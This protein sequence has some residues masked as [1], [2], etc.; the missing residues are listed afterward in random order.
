MASHF[1]TPQGR[2]IH[3]VTGPVPPHELL[4]EANWALDMYREASL[5]PRTS[6]ASFVS[7]AHQQAA[8][9]TMRPRDRKVHEFLATY[10]LAP[11]PY[12]YQPIFEK[13]LGER[14]STSAPRLAQASL[15]LDFARKTSRPLLFVLHDGQNFASPNFDLTLQR[16]INE[17]VVIVMPIR[18]APAL[19]QLTNQPP[20][21]ASGSA[22]PLFVVA[23]WDCRQ[24]AS[25]SGLN[26]QLLMRTLA[27]GWADALEQNPRSVG[28]LVR[29][30]QLLRKADPDAAER[31]KTLTIRLREEAKSARESKRDDSAK[32]VA[33]SAS[34]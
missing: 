6:Q 7:L 25:V 29:A 30:Q 27:S 1:L 18:E 31:V 15:R 8:M 12:A 19:S 20:Y 23:H 28:N 3:S 10:P 26:T 17:Y 14:V 13:I 34:L 32:L 4:E 24:I 11:L 16:L 33:R 2:L 21:V 5:Q 22:R 9:S